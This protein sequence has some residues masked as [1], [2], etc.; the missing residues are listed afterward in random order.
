MRNL[1]VFEVGKVT[2]GELTC[3][4]GTSGVNCT[5]SAADWKKAYDKAVD[6]VSRNIFSALLDPSTK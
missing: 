3:T 1:T 5:G 6:W 4:A 2:G